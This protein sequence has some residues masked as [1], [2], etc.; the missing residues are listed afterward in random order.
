MLSLL[1]TKPTIKSSSFALLHFRERLTVEIPLQGHRE[2]TYEGG[3]KR[4]A[5]VVTDGTRTRYQNG[6]HLLCK[7]RGRISFGNLGGTAGLM[8]CPI[9]DRTFFVR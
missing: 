5:L 7:L 4:F 1:G 9:R 8:S 3:R 2:W 6:L